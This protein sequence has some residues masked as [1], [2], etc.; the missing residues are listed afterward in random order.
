MKNIKD[1][2]CALTWRLLSIGSI[3]GVCALGGCGGSKEVP[4]ANA[5]PD[6]QAAAA[7]AQKSIATDASSAAGRAASEARGKAALSQA[8]GKAAP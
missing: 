7:A 1:P 3:M 4:A 8:A 6:P 2:K 5:P